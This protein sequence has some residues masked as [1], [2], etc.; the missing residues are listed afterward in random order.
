MSNKRLMFVAVLVVV[1]AVAFATV[2]TRPQASFTN[3][4][5]RHILYRADPTC[6][7]DPFAWGNAPMGSLSWN[8]YGDSGVVYRVGIKW[9]DG[10]MHFDKRVDTIMTCTLAVSDS[11]RYLARRYTEDLSRPVSEYGLAFFMWDTLNDTSATMYVDSV[12]FVADE[13]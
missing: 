9:A 10:T 4:A 13:Y 12:N 3:G 5:P 1:T 6:Q 11:V 7:T 8:A 2:K